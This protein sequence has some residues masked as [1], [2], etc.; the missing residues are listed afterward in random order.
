MTP[1]GIIQGEGRT[2]SANSTSLT[3]NSRT[4]NLRVGLPNL[5]CGQTSHQKKEE[6]VRRNVQI[7][8]DEAVG[9][10]SQTSYQR[11]ELNGGRKGACCLRETPKRI[12]KKNAKKP[13]TTQAANNACLRESFEIVIV[14]MVD[15]LSIVERFVRGEDK[16]QRAETSAGPGMVQEN[17]PGIG[18]H[19][20]TLSSGHLQGLKGRKPFEELL[21]TKPRN[22]EEYEQ[23][24]NSAR[25]QMFPGRT[26]NDHP[27]QQYADLDAEADDPSARRGK[28]QRADRHNGKEA[29]ENPA[30]AAH[31]AED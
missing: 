1:V 24:D 29:H 7:K 23:E 20:G 31:F 9:E 5:R 25:K 21:H 18:A 16:L 14:G 22:H 30:F 4:G 10:K 13:D 27:D 15:D 12:E 26:A 3:S 2:L 11:G 6:G 17:A 19:R 28:H 8:I